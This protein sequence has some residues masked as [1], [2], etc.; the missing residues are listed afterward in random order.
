MGHENGNSYTKETVFSRQSEVKARPS[1][2]KVWIQNWV[3]F[4]GLCPD[5]QF[6]VVTRWSA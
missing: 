1:V 2:I 3:D 6:P 4:A 5:M